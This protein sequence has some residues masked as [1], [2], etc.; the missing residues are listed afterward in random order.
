M[1]KRLLLGYTEEEVPK[2][3]YKELDKVKWMAKVNNPNYK[4]AA[5]YAFSMA[6]YAVISF[7][8]YLILSGEL[9]FLS[10]F[11]YAWKAALFFWIGYLI[12][13]AAFKIVD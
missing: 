4:K 9:N 7:I 11:N 3:V 13:L 10:I 8:M 2:E 5:K 1:L 12:F 6:K